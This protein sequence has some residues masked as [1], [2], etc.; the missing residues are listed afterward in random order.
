MKRGGLG[1]PVL[2]HDGELS[3]FDPRGTY[4]AAALDYESAS[5]DYWS[6]ASTRTVERLDL[7][8][9]QS[10]LDIACGTGWSALA[11][12]EKVGP[13][14]R[15]VAVDFADQMLAIARQKAALKGLDNIDFRSADVT[16]LGFQPASFNAVI[17]VLGVFFVN[18]MV[19][20]VSKM[21]DMVRPGGSLAVT[22]LGRRVF[23]PLID[24]FKAAVAGLRPDLQ[25]ML[26][27]ERTDE[28]SK[29]RALFIGAGI[30]DVAVD[31]EE[32]T[33]RLRSSDDWWRMVMGSSLRRY[34]TE[35]GDAAEHVRL[36]TTRWLE[37]NDLTSVELDVIYARATRPTVSD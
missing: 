29:T 26:P 27:W 13:S 37:R 31:V 14:G 36:E 7:A 10:V 2:D 4:D 28:P 32:N 20:L 9:G 16:S 22:N 18:D 3:R 19:S 34:V 24:E 5:R 6:F 1:G 33:L 25:V 35:L 15:V 11:A 21:W 8:P 23:W 30:A 12:A 17:S